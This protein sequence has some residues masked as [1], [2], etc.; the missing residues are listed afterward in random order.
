MNDDKILQTALE[1][2]VA[3][4]SNQ[5][6]RY[7]GA[8]YAFHPIRLATRA[9][10]H[11][12]PDHVVAALLLHDLVE[13]CPQISREQ[14]AAVAGVLELVLEVTNPSKGSE[15]PRAE[16][17]KMDREHVAKASFWGKYIKL[18]DRIDNIQ[19]MDQADNDFKILYARESLL[20]AEAIGREHIPQLDSPAKWH[21]LL[22]QLYNELVSRAQNM[23]EE[24]QLESVFGKKNGQE[25][26]R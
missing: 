17:K 8:P 21:G 4:H 23:L 20:L 14:I 25:N 1:L 9:K 19:E 22:V 5:K 13:D 24:S 2:C 12:V 3:A 15:L 11:G 26:V 16:R 10:Q 6:R 7:T 18:L